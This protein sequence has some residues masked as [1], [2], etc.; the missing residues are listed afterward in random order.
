MSCLRGHNFGP[1]WKCVDNYPQLTDD[2]DLKMKQSAANRHRFN[3]SH[4]SGQHVIEY[5]TLKMFVKS[6]FSMSCNKFGFENYWLKM[7]ELIG[8]FKICIS[9]I[10][11]FLDDLTF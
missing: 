3:F 4:V 10:K 5:L 6:L 7:H 9:V 2:V 11:T 8:T 1:V